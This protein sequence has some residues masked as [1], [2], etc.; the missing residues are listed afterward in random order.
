MRGK[1]MKLFSISEKESK[2]FNDK[3]GFIEIESCPVGGMICTE[4]LAFINKKIRFARSHWL[5]KNFVLAI[6]ELKIAY[7]KTAEINEPSC[8]QCAALFRTTITNSMEAI[9]DDLKD[10]TTGFFRAK[11]FQSSYELAAITLK[12]FKE[13]I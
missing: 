3:E 1:I 9:H 13:G 2:Y 5:N 7:Y 8:V 10:M 12:E 6:E 4:H 11:R